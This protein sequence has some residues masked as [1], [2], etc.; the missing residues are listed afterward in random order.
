MTFK[1][2][3]SHVQKIPAEKLTKIQQFI[4]ADTDLDLYHSHLN[5]NVLIIKFLL[6]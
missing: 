4:N 6:Q 1:L 2:V 5:T 3:G